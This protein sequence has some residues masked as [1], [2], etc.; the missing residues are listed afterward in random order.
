MRDRKAEE[1]RPAAERAAAA[2]APGD[3][4]RSRRRMEPSWAKS[5][6]VE[7][8]APSGATGTGGAELAKLKR[9]LLSE[10]VEENFW[11]MRGRRRPFSRTGRGR[12]RGWIAAGV[13]L[14]AGLAAA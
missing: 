10:A 12:G 11:P 2:L 1:V 4:D 9:R 5:W 14:S 6:G 8:R 7:P 3:R 13:L